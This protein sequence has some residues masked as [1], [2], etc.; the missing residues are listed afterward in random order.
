M[1][2]VTS[3]LKEL[4]TA[5][6]LEAVT[7]ASLP[8]EID[9]EDLHVCLPIFSIYIW[10]LEPWRL[11]QRSWI[12]FPFFIFFV[13]TFSVSNLG[14]L[15]LYLFSDRGLT[16][17]LGPDLNCITFWSYVRQVDSWCGSRLGLDS[18]PGHIFSVEQD[19]LFCVWVSFITVIYIFLY[20]ATI[21]QI[22]KI[23]LETITL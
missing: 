13:W 22:M 12:R 21:K 19:N 23:N 11:S 6:L 17:S 15:S 7:S 20:L 3:R 16:G 5:E 8:E 9:I 2:A 4:P 14:R 18:H 10:P 1:Q